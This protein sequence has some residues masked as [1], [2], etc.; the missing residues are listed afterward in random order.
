MVWTFS[1]SKMSFPPLSDG[2]CPQKPEPGKW[3]REGWRFY[4]IHPETCRALP[5]CHGN[6]LLLGVCSVRWLPRV[7]SKESF[8]LKVQPSSFI[9]NP[10]NNKFSQISTRW[11]AL[12]RWVHELRSITSLAGMEITINFWHGIQTERDKRELLRSLFQAGI[13]AY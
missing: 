3:V 5:V 10:N 9:T 6:C 7:R 8:T 1:S 4:V 13:V 2:R 12:I 11:Y